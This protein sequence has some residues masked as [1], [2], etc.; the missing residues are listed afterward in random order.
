MCPFIFTLPQ[1]VQNEHKWIILDKELW[2]KVV[3]KD[4]TR[5]CQIVLNPG[6]SFQS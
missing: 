6:Q 1:C 4:E 2:A 3:L 5:T